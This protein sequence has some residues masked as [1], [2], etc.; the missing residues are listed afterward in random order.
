MATKATKDWTPLCNRRYQQA[1]VQATQLGKMAA[2]IRDTATGNP[3]SAPVV[4]SVRL[5]QMQAEYYA[6]MRHLTEYYLHYKQQVE[7]NPQD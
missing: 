4:A 5:A 2:R 3:F 6:A 1:P 7:S